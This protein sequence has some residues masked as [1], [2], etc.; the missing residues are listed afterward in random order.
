[1]SPVAGRICPH[2]SRAPIAQTTDQKTA[3]DADERARLIRIRRPPIVVVAA[4]SSRV[5][6]GPTTPSTP[7]RSP[8]STRSPTPT[9]APTTRSGITR[10]VVVVV[11]F[12]YIMS[13]L[14]VHVFT[15]KQY[16]YWYK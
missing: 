10:V 9:R 3:T 4:S 16:Q 15:C 6:D 8:T 13:R 11:A 5:T 14:F 12:R 2:A 1:V 7:G